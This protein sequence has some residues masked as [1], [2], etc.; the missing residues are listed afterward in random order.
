MEIIVFFIA[1]FIFCEIIV[2]LLRDAV[3]F[4]TEFLALCVW[5]I[6]K[7]AGRILAGAITLIFRA[8]VWIAARTFDGL[9]WVA[10]RIAR[11]AYL[12]CVFLFYLAD[13][14][15][16]GPRE[17]ETAAE[18]EQ[19]EFSEQDAQAQAYEDALTLL[20]LTPG[21]NRT[22]LHA[23][24]KQAIKIAHPDAGGSVEQAQA[25]NA[26]RDLIAARMGWT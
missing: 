21:F 16:R 17:E 15:L 25:I 8:V 2:P 9:A 13:E 3:I 6:L 7:L 5:E 11:G 14:W 12:V 24:W 18:E 1:F 10:I 20:G 22:A 4:L 23:A 19:E 26:A